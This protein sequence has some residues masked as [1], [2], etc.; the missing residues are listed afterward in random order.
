M[1]DYLQEEK[2]DLRKA[3][4]EKRKQREEGVA[5]EEVEW[6]CKIE[7]IEGRVHVKCGLK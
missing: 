1:N 7:I 6:E 3:I 4:A 2:R 5:E